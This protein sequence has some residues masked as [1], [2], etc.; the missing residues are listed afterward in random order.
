MATL[1]AA[2]GGVAVFIAAVGMT[3]GGLTLPSRYNGTLAPPNVGELGLGQ[4][5]GGIG[6]LALSVVIVGSAAAL[7]ANLRGSQTALMVISA[8]T[9]L[10]G[11]A[12]FVLLMGASRRDAVL[13][14]ALGV[15]FLAFAGA[16]FV[17]ARLKP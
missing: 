2:I 10:L 16:A 5:F 8:I 7:L 14:A 6:L 11:A 17:L 3:I 13:L 9:A 1:V 12:G 4:I 15:A